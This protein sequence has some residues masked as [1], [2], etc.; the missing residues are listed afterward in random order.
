MH[1]GLGIDNQ[2]D[3]FVLRTEG[4]PIRLGGILEFGAGA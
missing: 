1:A 4:V 2:L 3:I